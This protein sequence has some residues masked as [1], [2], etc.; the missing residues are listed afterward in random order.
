MEGKGR[1]EGGGGRGISEGKNHGE[2]RS[3]SCGDLW[4]RGRDIILI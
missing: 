1:R 4:R 3:H 2:D